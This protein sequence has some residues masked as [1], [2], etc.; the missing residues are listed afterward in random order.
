MGPARNRW[1]GAS[2]VAALCLLAGAAPAGAGTTSDGACSVLD[3]GRVAAV[4]EAAVVAADART[5]EVGGLELR[6]CFYR[7][8]DL[9]RSVSFEVV[10]S[11]DDAPEAAT[12][13]WRELFHPPAAA[14]AP[15]KPRSRRFAGD[16]AP[17]DAATAGRAEALPVAGLG[18]EAFYVGTAVYGALYVLRGPV[19]LRLS[20]GGPG[21]LD[22][23]LA[24]AR[25]LAE[26]ALRRLADDPPVQERGAS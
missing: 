6:T 10:S 22:A 9:S 1:S 21:D 24:R 23:K 18:D 26:G 8:A 25:A 14:G 17:A 13:R 16:V 19:Y 20:V 7:A 12:R 5:R 3:P 15:E 2:A 4:Q 11:A